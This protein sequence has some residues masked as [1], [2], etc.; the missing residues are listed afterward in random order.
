MV[1]AVW[2][3]SG[4]QLSRGRVSI[5]CLKQAKPLHAPV[6]APH[7][8]IVIVTLHFTPMSSLAFA[9]QLAD[10]VF[11]VLTSVEPLTNIRWYFLLSWILVLSYMGLSFRREWMA[12]SARR[13]E[14]EEFNAHSLVMWNL[15]FQTQAAALERRANDAQRLAAE[16]TKKLA[17]AAKKLADVEAAEERRAKESKMKADVAEKLKDAALRTELERQAKAA[18]DEAARVLREQMRQAEAEAAVVE[19]VRTTGKLNGVC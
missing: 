19:R 7:S 8:T 12:D 2:P 11:D 3:T 17:D 4:L 13:R 6:L 15:H 14:V 5:H 1:A 16:A 10:W 18:G 9:S